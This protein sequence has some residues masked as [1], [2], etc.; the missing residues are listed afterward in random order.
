M[1]DFS[2]VIDIIPLQ[3]SKSIT[4]QLLKNGPLLKS[5]SLSNKIKYKNEKE[6]G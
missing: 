4:A 6:S 3:L 5:Q 1:H 2:L